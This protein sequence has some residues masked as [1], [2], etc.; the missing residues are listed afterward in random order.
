M[1]KPSSPGLAGRSSIHS[2]TNIN[3]FIIHTISHIFI[4]IKSRRH[5]ILNDIPIIF[6]HDPRDFSLKKHETNHRVLGPF[7]L[8]PSAPC[9]MPRIDMPVKSES[10]AGGRGRCSCIAESFVSA[11]VNMNGTPL[12]GKRLLGQLWT[13]IRF[14]G[15]SFRQSHGLFWYWDGQQRCHALFLLNGASSKPQK[16]RTCHLSLFYIV[17]VSRVLLFYLGFA[18]VQFLHILAQRCNGE[19]RCEVSN[20]QPTCSALRGFVKEIPDLCTKKGQNVQNAPQ[21]ASRSVLDL[22][23][24]TTVDISISLFPFCF[25]LSIWISEP[26]SGPEIC[27]TNSA[28]SASDCDLLRW[29]RLIPSSQ[30]WSRRTHGRNR[31]RRTTGRWRTGQVV[32]FLC[33]ITT[34]NFNGYRVAYFFKCPSWVWMMGWSPGERWVVTIDPNW[35]GGC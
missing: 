26:R 30:A 28:S 21:N 15:T 27:S 23:G 3:Q 4:V 32:F 35:A 13:T 20:A 33:W 1:L 2:R 8:H 11:I 12:N 16:D 24:F 29:W 31:R 34:G 7:S 18:I 10:M 6:H 9:E 25:F 19:P 17:Y 5:V 22:H 14:W